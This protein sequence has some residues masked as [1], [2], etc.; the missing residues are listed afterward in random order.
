MVPLFSLPMVV[1]SFTDTFLVVKSRKSIFSV[2]T[3]LKDD[4][5]V[6]L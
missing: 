3:I 4:V 6:R 5:E 2:L 1:V